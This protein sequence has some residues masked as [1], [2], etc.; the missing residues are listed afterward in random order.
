MAIMKPAPKTTSIPALMVKQWLSIWNGYE[1]DKSSHRAK[2]EDHFYIVSI[3]ASTLRAL[4]GVNRRDRSLPGMD[5]GIQRRHEVRRSEE[6]ARY[7]KYGFPYS[8]MSEAR[9][10]QP[11]SKKLRQPGWL[12]T[13]IVVNIVKPNDKYRGAAVSP[14]DIVGIAGRAGS[15]SM[16][17]PE[18]YKGGNWRP[19]ARYPIEIIDGQHRL[20]AFNESSDDFDVPVVAFH[21]L[22]VG[23]Q[24]YLFGRSTSSQSGSTRRSH[25]ICIRFFARKTGSRKAK[26]IRFIE[27]LGLRN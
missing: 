21:G 14:K 13:A 6:I 12:P 2:P 15:F 16:T 27:R 7:V 26:T 19:N 22:D 3:K 17:L 10:D 23:W 18:S 8:A 4:S 11:E 9:R 24:A 5:L 20:F 25:L 1:F